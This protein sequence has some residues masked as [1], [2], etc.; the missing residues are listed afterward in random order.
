ME[1]LSALPRVVIVGPPN[2][3]KSTLFNTLLGR[4]R[5]V[6]TDV[7]GTTRDVLTE[8]MHVDADDPFSAE[9][10]LTDIAGLDADDAGLNPLMQSA[11]RRAIDE[12]DLIVYLHPA[13]LDAGARSRA[14]AVHR[15]VFDRLERAGAVMHVQ[16]KSDCAGDDTRRFASYDVEISAVDHA[17]LD[18]LRTL[19][20]RRL[21]DRT[22]SLAG[23]AIALEARHEAAL[24]TTRQHIDEVRGLIRDDAEREPG[25]FVRD[26]E[27]TAVRLRLAL[28]ALGRITGEVTPDDVLGHIF[29]T[30][31]VGK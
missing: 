30:F 7:S 19:I 4:E 26:V 11:A 8:P 22:S 13:D 28:D 18:D 3:G 12:A 23:D 20:G 9:I 21:A 10:L 24:T 25:G 14:E 29:A 17:R 6:V 15:E 31:C 1:Q 5:A 27:L 16:S 2:A